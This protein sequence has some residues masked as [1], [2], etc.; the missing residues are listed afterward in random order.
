MSE[1]YKIWDIPWEEVEAR[2]RSIRLLQPAEDGSYIYP[3][4]HAAISL[5]RFKVHEVQP[6]SLYVVRKNLFY[7]DRITNELSHRGR[8]PLALAGGLRVEREAGRPFD[9][10]PP[11]VEETPADGPHLLDGL[12][13][14][15]AARK[16]NS[17]AFS[18]VHITDYDHESYPS[19]ALPNLWREVLEVDEAPAEPERKHRY[20][21]PDTPERLK[22]DFSPLDGIPRRRS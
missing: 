17:I 12:Y 15:Y 20:R 6:T 2:V 21:E 9:I 8:H 10:V 22:R 4:E 1:M 19:Y 16:R 5:R 14:V 18:C 13:R 3:Y 7:Q 11:V